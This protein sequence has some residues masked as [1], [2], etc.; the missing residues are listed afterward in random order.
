M[1]TDLVGETDLDDFPGAPYPLLIVQAAAES[2]RRD[3]G[4][5]IAP[6][7]EET[8]TVD[9]TDGRELILPT[10]RIVAIT[11]IRDVTDPDNP[12]VLDDWRVANVRGI[13]YRRIGW[14]CEVG[15][16]EVDLTHGYATCPPELFPEV[17]TRCRAASSAVDSTIKSTQIDDFKESYTESHSEVGVGNSSRV[18]QFSVDGGFA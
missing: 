2:L 14:P 4:W 11:E 16:I 8:L 9:G 6:E 7:V 10:L 13:V 5:H 12:V 1:P 17:A 18:A 15:S 3:C